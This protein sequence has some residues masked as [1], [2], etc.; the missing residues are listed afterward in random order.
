MLSSITEQDFPAGTAGQIH[1]QVSLA[2]YTSF[3]V[4]GR[5]DC[6]FLPVNAADLIQGLAGLPPGCPVTFLGLGSNVLVRDGGIEGVVVITQKG[7]QHISVTAPGLLR[8][9]AGVACGRL[10]RYASRLGLAGLEFMAG[11]P[12]TTGGALAMNAGCYGG[13]TWQ[14]V[15][16]VET[17]DR[18]GRQFVREADKFETAYRHVRFPVSSASSAGQAAGGDIRE[19]FLAAHFHLPPGDRTDSLNHIRTMLAQ[20]NAAQP[21]GQPSCGSVFRNPPGGHAARLIEQ[22]GLKG[23]CL[24]GAAVS[25]RHANFIVNTGTASA[26]DIENLLEHVRETVLLKTGVSL[27]PEVHVMGRP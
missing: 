23:L 25:D 12:G 20:R 14:R 21:T 18:L 19:W 27:V 17:I 9:E 16:R 24:G 8:V 22:C 1:C 7:L 6:L 10:A 2:E 4:G 5:A 26:R 11:I 13:E 15:C 3:R